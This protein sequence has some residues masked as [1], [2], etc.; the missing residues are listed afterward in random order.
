MFDQRCKNQS[1]S[2]LSL[3]SRSGAPLAQTQ[4][5]LPGANKEKRFSREETD[6]LAG[7]VKAQERAMKRRGASLI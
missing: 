6:L 4:A 5:G 1:E 7:L 2:L 3:P